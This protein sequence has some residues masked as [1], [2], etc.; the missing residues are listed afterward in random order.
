MHARESN[1]ENHGDISILPL[2]RLKP[3]DIFEMK[4]A[5]YRD[6][7][8]TR[9]LRAHISSRTSILITVF[10]DGTCGL[11]HRAVQFLLARDTAGERFRYA[12][13]QGET[14]QANLGDLPNQIDSMIVQTPEGLLL[15]RSQAAIRLGK[16]LGGGWWVLA[17]MGQIVPRFMMDAIYDWIAR[18]RYGWFGQ[19][20]D[21]CPWL[22]PEQRTFFLD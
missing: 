9:A 12:P 15:I 6:P 21:A 19:V 8:P 17:S 11:C 3:Q 13:L 22:P 20:T 14:A 5:L 18:R 1:E 10:Y 4:H 7:S 16:A 2:P